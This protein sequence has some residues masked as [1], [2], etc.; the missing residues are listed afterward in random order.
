ML[1]RQTII[2]RA[3]ELGFEDVGFTT[4]E[5]FAT[6]DEILRSREES[7]SWLKNVGVDL[8]EGT[9]PG[10]I[11]AGAASIIVLIDCYCREAFPASLVGKFGRCYLDDDRVGPLSRDG[12]VLHARQP[13]DEH[14]LEHCEHGQLHRLD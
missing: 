2:D 14:H 11:M 9:D 10:K 12:V 8:M 13:D 3:L 5:P 1:S 7:Y 4:A 6:Q